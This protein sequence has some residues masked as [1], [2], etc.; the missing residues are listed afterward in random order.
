MKLAYQAYDKNGK[1]VSATIEAPGQSEAREALRREGLFV[2]EIGELS[3]SPTATAKRSWGRMRRGL[4]L[5]NLAM[6]SRQLHIL[7]SSGTPLVQA[8]GA[9]E[10]QAHDEKWRS[11]IASLREEVEEGIPLSQ[12]MEKQSQYFDIVCR[13]LIAAG[14]ASGN[15][16]VMLE[17]LCSLVQKQLH[18][19]RT[20]VGAMIYPCLLVFVGLGVLTLMLL[21]VLPRFVEL[22]NT[23][24]VKLPPTTR[25]LVFLSN[26]LQE[27][28][29]AALA[30]VVTGVVGIRLWISSEAG[31]K[32]VQSIVLR[33]PKMGG[34]VKNLVT[35]RMARLLGVLLESKVSLLEALQLTRQ[36]E[37]NHRYAE[38]IGNAELAVSRGEPISAAFADADLINPSIYE[39]I[40][41]GEQSGQV[42]SLLLHMAGFMDE[43][44]EIVVKSL[45]TLIEPI[46]LLCLGVMVALIALSM[47]MPLF[48]LAATAQGGGA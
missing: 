25:V 31:H 38:L 29:W 10:R 28:W 12:A 35:A 46:I 7:V 22:F 34:L 15:M 20:I 30:A 39:T 23:L 48:D 44:N 17:R 8:L 1:A 42:G 33:V 19:R 9:M 37:T 4:R 45:M 21:F 24:D 11:V 13:T 2:T 36:A 27:Y 43:E 47:F 41:N 18:L 5:K 6:F 16:G 26:G 3:G 40:R 14:E 32:I